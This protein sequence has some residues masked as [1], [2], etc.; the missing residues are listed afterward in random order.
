MLHINAP[1]AAH[2]VELRSPTLVTKVMYIFYRMYCIWTSR[3]HPPASSRV[4]SITSAVITAKPSSSWTAHPSRDVIHLR[5]VK[6]YP[7]CT[8]TTWRPSISIWPSPTWPRSICKK[9]CR[10]TRGWR[11]SSINQS[12][13]SVILSADNSLF[14]SRWRS[15]LNV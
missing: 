8:S 6:I 1:F 11:E 13:V 3:P 2:T 12:I 14:P 5:L 7:W 10:K 9:P 4:T 15:N